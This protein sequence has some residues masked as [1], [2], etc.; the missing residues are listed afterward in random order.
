[1]LS[2]GD[3]TF[4]LLDITSFI[5]ILYGYLFIL[6]FD[7]L[8]VITIYIIK[9]QCLKTLARRKTYISIRKNDF[10]PTCLYIFGMPVVRKY[11]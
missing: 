8:N 1:M 11:A 5:Y 6:M 7:R 4:A 3:C 10:P 9:D 2:Y